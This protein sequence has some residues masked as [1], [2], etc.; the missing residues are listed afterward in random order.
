MF[1]SIGLLFGVGE[2][3]VWYGWIVML[4]GFDIVEVWVDV[5]FVWMGVGDVLG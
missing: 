3:F 2:V 1:F 4:L 5:V